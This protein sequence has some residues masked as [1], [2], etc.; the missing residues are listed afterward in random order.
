VNDIRWANDVLFCTDLFLHDFLLVQATSSTAKSASQERTLPLASSNGTSAVREKVQQSYIGPRP[1][2]IPIAVPEHENLHTYVQR[3]RNISIFS[4]VFTLCCAGVGLGFA[5][6]TQRCELMS[7]AK[8]NL[9]SRARP[10]IPEVPPILLIMPASGIHPCVA[11]LLYWDTGW[12]P[13]LMSG[14]PSS[15]CGGS[16]V[17]QK[18][19]D[20][21]F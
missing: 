7:Q 10:D 1:G 16:G 19:K 17:I 14:A 5:W 3:A 4:I 2:S 21:I 15:C 8:R 11:V 6:T 12:K 18:A 20:S 9:P 13:W